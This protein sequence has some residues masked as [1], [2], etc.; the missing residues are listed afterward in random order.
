M[1]LRWFKSSDKMWITL[2]CG[3]Q[4]WQ[5]SNLYRTPLNWRLQVKSISQEREKSGF[6]SLSDNL[7]IKPSYGA[8]NMDYFPF[9]PI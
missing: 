7:W 3:L 5:F 6:L 1:Q 2:T 4:Y 8:N 9:Q